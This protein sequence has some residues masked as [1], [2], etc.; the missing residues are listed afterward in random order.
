M[1]EEKT[2]DNASKVEV[3]KID[4]KDKSKAIEIK[5]LVI[6]VLDGEEYGAEITDLQEII[7]KTEITPI[8]N[9][10]DF[11]K[12]IIN[13]RGKIVVV[14]D[15]EQRFNLSREKD[16]EPVHILIAEVGGST[17]GV[18]VDHVEEVLSVPT[19]NIRAT[20]TMMSPKIDAGYIKGV[21]V[22]EEEEIKKGESRLIVLLDLPMLLETKELMSFG[23]LVKS[24]KSVETKEQVEEV[25]EK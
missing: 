17:F 18:L 14:V 22:F 9:S 8:P 25:E 4:K 13:L 3:K 20:P 21:V 16:Q 6:F 23:E 10:P 1:Q 11:V 24:D 7:K 2:A 19:S 12:G 5:Q 15:L